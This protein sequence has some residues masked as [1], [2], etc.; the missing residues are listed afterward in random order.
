M[1]TPFKVLSNLVW[2]GSLDEF[3]NSVCPWSSFHSHKRKIQV[4][5]NAS[6]QTVL[7]ENILTSPRCFITSQKMLRLVVVFYSLWKEIRPF[8]IS[9]HQDDRS[10]PDDSDGD[11][12]FKASQ[13]KCFGPHLDWIA[14][15]TLH[16]TNCDNH[17]NS[18][19][20]L[21]R[22]KP[23]DVKGCFFFPFFSP[24]LLDPV[25]KMHERTNS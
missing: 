2:F 13:F 4:N 19:F 16:K 15:F 8:T 14:A 1:A 12:F 9:S 6:L 18:L 24:G 7:H 3:V 22:L 25:S 20:V 17:K 11:D 23:Q 5:L 21:N 10:S